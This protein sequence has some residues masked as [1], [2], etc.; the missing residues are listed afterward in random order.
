[1]DYYINLSLK[2]FVPPENGW[3]NLETNRCINEKRENYTC[4]DDLKV[5]GKMET[6]CQFLKINRLPMPE[7]FENYNKNPEKTHEKTYDK[8]F[9][10]IDIEHIDENCLS[11][12]AKFS[13][14]CLFVKA[15]VNK[16]V[17]G[18]TIDLYCIVPMNILCQPR[19]KKSSNKIQEKCNALVG[20]EMTDTKMLVKLRCRLFGID[21]ADKD[22]GKKK[23]GT[24]YL[25]RIIHENNNVVYCYFLGKGARGRELV[26]LYTEPNSKESINNKILKYEDPT[27]GKLAYPYFGGTKIVH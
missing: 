14:D 5:T 19:L 3:Y 17:D 4:L 27:F 23:A 7:K 2:A 8:N 13:F 24:E 22:K 26:E 18:D 16:V 1:M 15:K 11:E 25:K 21:T 9:N 6:V 10:L 12:L 20:N